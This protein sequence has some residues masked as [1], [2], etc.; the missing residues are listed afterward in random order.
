MRMTNCGGRWCVLLLTVVTL[1]A[2]GRD[3]PLVDAVKKSDMAAVHALL[4]QPVDVNAAEPDG[5]TALHWAVHLDDLETTDLLIRA[6]ATV[7]AANRYGVVPL[8]LACEN[9]NA[10]MIERL[11]NAGADPNA[12]VADGETALMTVARTG[13]ADAVRVLLARGADVNA[14]DSWRGQ[15]ALMWAAI[16]NNAAAAQVLLEA[17][18]DVHARSNF[19]PAAQRQIGQRPGGGEGGFTPLLFAVRGGHIETARVLLAM[20]ANANDT[21]PGGMN[22]LVVAVVNAH[23]ELAAFLLDEGGDPNADA[24]GWTALHQLVWTR[25]PNRGFAQ[26]GPVQTGSLD[27]LDL[28]DELVAH[29]A[30]VNAQQTQEPTDRYRNQL[31]RIGATP[32]LLAAKSADVDLMRVLL[33]NGADPLLPTADN[34]A[35]LMVAAGVGIWNVGESPGT[36]AEALEAVKLALELGGDVTAANDNGYTALHGAAH[37]GSPAIVQLLVDKGAQLDA[38]VTKSGGGA[39]GWY[40]GWT[41]LIIADGVFYAGSFKRSLEVAALLRQLMEARGLPTDEPA[42]AAASDGAAR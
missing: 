7:T 25:R 8:S 36:N 2:A 12:I 20:G 18:A 32:F 15:T 30:D 22:T 24:Q 21:L 40:E 19:A 11:L 33:A 38:K 1:G 4:Q 10:V 28:V 26:P 6:G 27:S 14:K 5:T 17:G 16:E 39:S 42:V 35:P 37:R 34:S 41:P 31:D 29:G 3:V 13:N 23:Y 9:G